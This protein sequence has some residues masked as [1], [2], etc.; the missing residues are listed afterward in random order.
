MNRIV[1]SLTCFAILAST[2]F[3]GVWVGTGIKQQEW[4]A[5]VLT[6]KEGEEAALKA[7]ARAITKIG[8]NSDKHLPQIITEVRTNTVYRDCAHGPDS[9]RNL[10]ALIA[11]ESTGDGGMPEG[12]QV[13]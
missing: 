5:S 9:L 3:G 8:A 7:A 2:F 1:G 6:K 13:D 10:N 12:N 11:G 4:D